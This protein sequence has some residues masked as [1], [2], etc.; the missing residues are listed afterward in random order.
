[1][2]VASPLLHKVYDIVSV[3][4]PMEGV[5]ANHE[6]ETCPRMKIMSCGR[7]RLSRM[8][9]SRSKMNRRVCSGSGRSG[10]ARVCKMEI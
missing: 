7:P 9:A 4:E 3:G 10:Y 2:I 1:M 5:A 8:F 6:S